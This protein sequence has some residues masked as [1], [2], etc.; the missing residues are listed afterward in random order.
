M[1]NYEIL[2]A[3]IPV[4]NQQ[5]QQFEAW[6]ESVSVKGGELVTTMPSVQPDTV[7]CIFRVQTRGLIPNLDSK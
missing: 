1:I 2:P 7:L 5:M 4:N 3:R 6:L